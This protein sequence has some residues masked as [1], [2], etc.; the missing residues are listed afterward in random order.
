MRIVL[1]NLVNL[2]NEGNFAKGGIVFKYKFAANI[3]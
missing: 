1:L 3:R 2:P